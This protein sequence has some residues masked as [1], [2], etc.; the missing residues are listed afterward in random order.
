MPIP[1]L[2][3]LLGNQLLG[4]P[5]GN[6]LGGVLSGN[7]PTNTTPNP[8]SSNFFMQQYKSAPPGMKGDWG[9]YIPDG[10]TTPKALTNDQY[11]DKNMGIYGPPGTPTGPL[12]AISNFGKGMD[13]AGRQASQN[14]DDGKYAQSIIAGNPYGR[15]IGGVGAALDTPAHESN[16]ISKFD[17][18]RAQSQFL[19]PYAKEE[20]ERSGLN[21]GA[22]QRAN[23]GNPSIPSS[24]NN[25]KGVMGDSLFRSGGLQ[26]R[27][28]T[29]NWSPVKN[30]IDR[31]V[32]DP[33]WQS[34]ENTNAAIAALRGQGF[35]NPEYRTPEQ[36]MVTA[37]ND[38][39]A[40]ANPGPSTVHK[41][42][43]DDFGTPVSPYTIT[44]PFD[45]I[46]A[47][48]AQNNTYGTPIST[49]FSPNPAPIS[50]GNPN[51]LV[52]INYGTLNSIQTSRLGDILSSPIGE[53]NGTQVASNTSGWGGISD[54][55]SGGSSSFGVNSDGGWDGSASGDGWG[56]WGSDAASDTGS[57]TWDSSSSGFSW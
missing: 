2:T 32:D 36:R 20:F 42:D 30:G 26:Y 15:L 55:D 56:D 22:A 12:G 48:D 37:Q 33:N 57:D 11:W 13:A 40:K 51:D 53:I 17:P 54:I 23:W 45:R 7:K 4:N 18:Y 6:L 25:P 29:G 24:A 19:D 3:G 43:T 21:I 39:Y 34:K 46:D 14:W 10:S 27:S 16:Y 49:N 52:G 1:L 28:P 47:I 44:D 35:G 31:S 38:T 50:T 5:I 8:N 9:S 41:G